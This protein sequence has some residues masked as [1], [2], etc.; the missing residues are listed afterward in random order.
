MKRPSLGSNMCHQPSVLEVLILKKM[1][2]RIFE[3]LFFG[4]PY[5]TLAASSLL[6]IALRRLFDELKMMTPLSQNFFFDFH[7]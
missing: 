7:I 3:T 5:R 1:S 4:H 6:D 2:S